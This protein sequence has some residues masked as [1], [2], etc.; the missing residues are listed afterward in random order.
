MIFLRVKLLLAFWMEAIVGV[1][2]DLKALLC[3]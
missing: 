1:T 2:S 3:A